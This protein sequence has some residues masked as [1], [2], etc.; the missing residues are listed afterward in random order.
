MTGS[1]A[2]SSGLVAPT[3]GAAGDPR[4]Q[5]P[6]P[7]GICNKYLSGWPRP[8]TYARAQRMVQRCELVGFAADG[9]D[10]GRAVLLAPLQR[11]KCHSCQGPVAFADQLYDEPNRWQPC[12]YTSAIG[13]CPARSKPTR[14]KVYTAI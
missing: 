7:H 4:M 3:A 8:L 2:G 13:H 12:K 9:P 10:C 6:S 5:T 1:P 11:Y 14:W